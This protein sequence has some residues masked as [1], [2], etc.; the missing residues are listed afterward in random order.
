MVLEVRIAIHLFS[1]EGVLSSMA[2]YDKVAVAWGLA[3]PHVF[4]KPIPSSGK[5][6]DTWS[7]A[8]HLYAKRGKCGIDH[9]ILSTH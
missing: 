4:L 2:E 1:Q 9:K 3:R 6:S 8:I 7:R 5:L